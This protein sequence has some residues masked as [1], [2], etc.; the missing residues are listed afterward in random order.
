MACFYLFIYYLIIYFFYCV[1]GFV[2]LWVHK[3]FEL[4]GLGQFAPKTLPFLLNDAMLILLLNIN[5]R[6]R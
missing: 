2:L 6:L 3:G 1:R 4:Q 5:L